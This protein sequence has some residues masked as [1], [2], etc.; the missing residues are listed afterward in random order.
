[1]TDL[2]HTSTMIQLRLDRLRT[3]DLSAREEL[4]GIACRRLS[5]LA[6]RMLGRFRG[7]SRWEQTDDVLQNASLRLFRALADVRPSSVR[8]FINLAA[9]QIRRE[10]IDLCRH[11]DGPHGA[12]RHHA[13]RDR[14][15]G[16]AGRHGTLDGVYDSD[17]PDRLAAWTE[18]HDTIANL[19]YEE[20]EVFHLLWYQGLSQAEA[21]ALIG[22]SERVVKY[23]WRSAR[24]A[25]HR[26]LGGRLPG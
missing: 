12:G 16:P 9:V 10:L 26:T 14:S 24:L 21:A 15:D 6:H 19:P 8:S 1:M 7:V 22:V 5:R 13:S 2:A 3:G 11:Y 4:L 18:F 17:G 25:V 20:R 23:R